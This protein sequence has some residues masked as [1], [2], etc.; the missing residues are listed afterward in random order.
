M[1]EFPASVLAVGHCAV[2]N[3][4]CPINFT[5]VSPIWCLTYLAFACLIAWMGSVMGLVGYYE[6][7]TT[8]CPLVGHCEFTTTQCPE[9]QTEQRS[10]NTNRG[11]S[12]TPIKNVISNSKSSNKEVL[13]S[14]ALNYSK[15]QFNLHWN[16]NLQLLWIKEDLK[17]LLSSGISN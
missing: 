16:L 1:F 3:S 7:T 11:R 9:T 8:Q 13:W 12:Q 17:W 14:K 4:R 2:L 10:S 15:L 5:S 6:F